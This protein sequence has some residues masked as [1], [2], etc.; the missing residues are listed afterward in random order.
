MSIIRCPR[1]HFYDDEKYDSCPTCSKSGG[2][3]W[4]MDNEKTV[5][6]DM[7]GGGVN[8]IRLTAEEPER[9]QIR[10][11]WDSEKTVALTEYEKPELLVGWLVCISGPMKGKDYRLYCGFNRLGRNMDSDICVQDPEVAGT[12]HCAVVYDEKG[13][14]FYL[15]PGKGSSTYLN[16]EAIQKAVKLQERDRIQVGSSILEFVPFCKGDYTWKTI[17]TL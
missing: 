13:E 5:S 8:E 7:M 16:Q 4:Q 12:M 10:G 6:L 1:G 17:Q 14:C 3:G 15:T 11:A 9:Q 2:F